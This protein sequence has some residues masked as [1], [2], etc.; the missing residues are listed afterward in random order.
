MF[1]G[2]LEGLEFVEVE[3]QSEEQA[4]GFN[5]PEW[6]GEDVTFDKRYRNSYLSSISD[7][8]EILNMK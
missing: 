5:P 1:H 4:N 7:M 6:F 8:S 3:F 2:Y